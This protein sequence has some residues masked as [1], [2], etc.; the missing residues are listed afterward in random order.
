M[1]IQLT[2]LEG[3]WSRKINQSAIPRNR[4]SRRSR[5]VVA[6][7]TGECIGVIFIFR[8]PADL[9]ILLPRHLQ[10]SR[11]RDDCNATIA[12]GRKRLFTTGRIRGRF[13]HIAAEGPT[14]TKP[15]YRAV[16]RQIEVKASPTFMPDRSSPENGY[17]F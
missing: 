8:Q 12:S 1:V 9:I 11:G 3:M 5:P 10:N 7:T 15:A 14:M 6:M 16:T 4:S 13:A 2:T 17:F